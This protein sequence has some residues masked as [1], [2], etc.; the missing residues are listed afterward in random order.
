[1]ASENTEIV[2]RL[3]ETLDSADPEAL[4][5]AV[6]PESEW[7][8]LADRTQ[9]LRGGQGLARW[10]REVARDGRRLEP[11]IVEVEDH[12]EHVIAIGSLRVHERNGSFSEVSAA[13][14]YEVRDGAIRRSEGFSSV[15]EARG[16]LAA[17]SREVA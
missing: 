7:V 12:G 11:A 3:W 14:L 10:L 8:P 2:L 5:G 16:A 6:H 15:T 9:R 13:W 1:L 17:L 4:T